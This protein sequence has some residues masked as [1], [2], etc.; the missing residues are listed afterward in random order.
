MH[1]YLINKLHGNYISN[2]EKE[3]KCVIFKTVA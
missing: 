3:G 1:I 2:G